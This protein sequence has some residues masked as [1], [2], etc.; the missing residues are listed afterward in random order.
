MIH[1]EVEI[2]MDGN[3][4]VAEGTH[5]GY[6]HQRT[7]FHHQM[8]MNTIKTL[9]MTKT[10]RKKYTLQKEK[11]QNIHYNDKGTLRQIKNYWRS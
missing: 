3:K 4:T 10:A 8:T 2:F 6:C 7:D 5:E 11:I 9:R 1:L